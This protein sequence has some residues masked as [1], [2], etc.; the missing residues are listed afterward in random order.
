M[1]KLSKNPVMHGRNKYIIVRYHFFHDLSNDGVIEVKYR[2][3][4]EQIAIIMTKLLKL[5]GFVKLQEQ[6]GVCEIL[7]V[8][9]RSSLNEDMLR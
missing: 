4:L 8:V 9:N 1:I 3:S 5:D 6:L 7:K 2:S